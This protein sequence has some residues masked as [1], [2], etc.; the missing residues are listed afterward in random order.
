MNG[1]MYNILNIIKEF[2][3][4]EYTESVYINKDIPNQ[5]FNDYSYIKAVIKNDSKS[6]K[7]VEFLPGYLVD[8]KYFY[9]CPLQIGY[10][11]LSE[12]KCI[13]IKQRN[14][15]Y[16]NLVATLIILEQNQKKQEIEIS[17]IKGN[18][19]FIFSELFK[20]ISIINHFILTHGSLSKMNLTKFYDLIDLN[21]TSFLDKSFI[22]NINYLLLN[23]YENSE[24][25][26]GKDNYFW[27]EVEVRNLPK[28][29]YLCE[30]IKQELLQSFEKVEIT[31]YGLLLYTNK[32][33]A[34]SPSHG[35]KKIE[36]KDWEISIKTTLV[37]NLKEKANQFIRITKYLTNNE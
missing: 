20:P 5:K 15:T 4:I 19:A 14:I 37:Y 27:S 1:G 26:V 30:L 36:N 3:F 35:R 17:L 9:H 34:W 7:C 21:K 16:F 25:R 12:T 28:E 2:P 33:G 18:F 13:E 31:D 22:N 23:F 32:G 29:D 24:S 6:P 10:V 8:D 11:L